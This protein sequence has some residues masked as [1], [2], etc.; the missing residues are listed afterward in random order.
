MKMDYQ[1]SRTPKQLSYHV[2]VG[3]DFSINE[4]FYVYSL[5][6]VVI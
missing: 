1:L 4:I 2:V 3:Y 6:L 5:I